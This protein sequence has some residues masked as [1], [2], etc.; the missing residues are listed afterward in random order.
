VAYFRTQWQL[1]PPAGRRFR[2]AASLKV[3]LDAAHAAG[4]TEVN[5]LTGINHLYF[6]LRA[7]AALT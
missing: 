6:D 4:N 7:T 1:G 3:A 2:D 5:L